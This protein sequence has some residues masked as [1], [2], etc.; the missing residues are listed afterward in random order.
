M[1]YV[2]DCGNTTTCFAQWQHG[3][4]TR[5]VRLVDNA[6]PEC[7]GPEDHLVILP[8]NAARAAEARAAWPGVC[9]YSRVPDCGQYQNCGE[10]RVLAGCAAIHLIQ[11]DVIVVDAGTAI[12]VTAWRFSEKA[13]MYTHYDGGFIAPGPRAMLAGLPVVAPALPTVEWGSDEDQSPTAAAMLGAVEHGIHGMVQALLQQLRQQTGITQVILTGGNRKLCC[14]DGR[15]EQ[16]L[17]LT[18]IGLV[19]DLL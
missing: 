3:V 11:D 19:H 8:G 13:P 6:Y 9:S 10:D 7:C 2:A 17:L 14:L 4:I 5:A 12:T 1:L 16:E 18:G 15:E